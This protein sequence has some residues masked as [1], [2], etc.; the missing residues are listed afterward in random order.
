MSNAEIAIPQAFEVPG[1]HPSRPLTTVIRPR[2]GWQALD[3]AE[4]WR[5]R[6]LLFFLT[7]RD[8]KVRYK[9]TVLGAAWAILQPL[10]TMIVFSIFFGRLAGVPS[11]RSP[12]RSSCS[13]GCS[14]GR[15]SPTRSAARAERRG[16]RA[17]DHQDLLPPDDHP[18]R[19]GR[20]RP[21]RLPHRL[22][23]ARRAD[24]LL[25]RA[26]PPA[27]VL[28][29]LFV[30]GLFLA[31]VGVGTLL[32]ALNVAYRDFRY[33]VPFM[34][35]LW[36]FATPTIYMQPD[37]VAQFALEVLP[38]AEPGLRADRNFRAACWGGRSTCTRWASRC[39]R[40]GLFR[41]RLPLLPPRR[42][43]LRRHHLI[44]NDHEQTQNWHRRS[45]LLGSEPHPEL[46]RLSPDRGRGRLRRE[47]RAAGGGRAQL[48]SHPGCRL[49]RPAAGA[50]PRRRRDRHAG[51]DALP[52]R[53]ALP[54][55]RPARAGREAPGGHRPRGSRRW[56]TWPSGTAAC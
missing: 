4:L 53:R 18:D 52:A 40:C 38:A 45:G 12:T 28:A 44:G 31:A 49:A 13:P 22:R 8:V 30:G 17:A 39:R 50:A 36:M 29:P 5:Y 26:P 2:R 14:P 37:R 25:R 34:V 11:G 33:V 54:G 16:Q 19:G 48:R 56:S 47:P 20:G 55:G 32:A 7:W 10:M 42:A 27:V 51:L 24:G 41:G 6:E 35:Q 21:G 46:L 15:S 3:L 43:G 23:H 1:K 9:Q